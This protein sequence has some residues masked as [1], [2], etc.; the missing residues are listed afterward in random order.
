MP[1]L[2]LVCA[3]LTCH[4]FLSPRILSMFWTAFCAYLPLFE[5]PYLS[6]K[7]QNDGFFGQTPFWNQNKLSREKV[8]KPKAMTVSCQCTF[9]MDRAFS[10]IPLLNSMEEHEIPK[11]TLFFQ[12]HYSFDCLL[13]CIMAQNNWRIYNISADYPIQGLI[14]TTEK[15]EHLISHP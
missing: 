14:A 1:Y 9:N 15:E 12:I 10:P 3:E 7:L 8:S 2:Y 13:S 5:C 4:L 11:Q 6:P